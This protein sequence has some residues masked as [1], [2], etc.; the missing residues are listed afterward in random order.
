MIRAL[1]VLLL[2]ALALTACS[3]PNDPQEKATSASPILYE[4]SNAEGETEGWLFGTIHALPD[5]VK[6]ETPALS[7]VIDN[8]D[9][10][11]VEVS[12]LA[13]TRRISRTFSQ[14]ARTPGQPNI[15]ARITPEHLPELESLLD[16]GNFTSRDFADVETWAAALMLAQASS[17]ASANNGVDRALLGRFRSDAVRELEGVQTQLRIFDQLPAQDQQDLLEGVLLEYRALE[18]GPDRL[19]NAWI[20]GDE[21]ALTQISRSGIMADPEL[22]EALLAQR[23]RNWIVGISRFL[24][25]DTQPL[26]AVGTAHLVGQDGL[27]SLLEQRGYTLTRIQ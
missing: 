21:E 8:A 22:Y 12:D 5:G 6:W 15:S 26:I 23:N 17:A 27:V 10:L 16:K 11:V 13:D 19:R 14:L 4:I 20:T 7:K 25:A 24:E 1:V 9:L 18:S 3:S 2:G